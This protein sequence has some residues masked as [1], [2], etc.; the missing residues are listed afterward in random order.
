MMSPSRPTI[1]R[2]PDLLG[3]HIVKRYA[4]DDKAV[5]TWCG[6]VYVLVPDEVAI[7]TRLADYDPHS[8]STTNPKG[9]PL[10][11]CPE[12]L[13]HRDKAGHVPL[14][15]ELRGHQGH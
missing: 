10:P 1:A 12:C 14:G 9:A 4:D 8:P 3:L 15:L 13:P 6:E 5:E 2:T 7:T 11:L